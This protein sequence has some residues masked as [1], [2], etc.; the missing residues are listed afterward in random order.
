LYSFWT[1]QQRTQASEAWEAFFAATRSFLPE[2][3]KLEQIATQFPSEDVGLWSRIVLGDHYLA[4]GAEGLFNDR[5]RARASLEKAVEN[6]QY[7]LDH[8]RQDDLRERAEFGL[9]RAFEAQG[10]LDKA[11][12]RYQ[13]LIQNAP[14]GPFSILARSRLDDLDRERTK[15]FYDW[16]AKHEPKS[17][18]PGAPATGEQ[19]PFDF[20][21]LPTPSSGSGP[22]FLEMPQPP[23]ASGKSPPAAEPGA[24]DAASPASEAKPAAS[25]PPA[26]A[27][28]PSPASAASP[29]DPSGAGPKSD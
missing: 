13:V 25:D 6:Y 15:E 21:S 3:E 22:S 27:S 14:N 24:P 19:P 20:D 12:Q 1:N 11:R 17:S 10:E 18:T 29:D 16:F 7:V 23:G 4:D 2:T 28:P 9:A 5:P 8:T 26:E